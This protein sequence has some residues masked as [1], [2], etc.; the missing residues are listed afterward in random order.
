MSAFIVSS[1]GSAILSSDV[2]SLKIDY[3]NAFNS[4][5]RDLVL[6][7]AHKYFPEY[8][9]YLWQC[10]RHPSNLFFSNSQISSEEGVQQGDPLGPLLFSLAINEDISKLSSELN[11]WYL[12]DGNLADTPEK[13]SADLG[14]LLSLSEKQGLA[15]NSSKC[16]LII[17]DDN[18]ENRKEIYQMFCN[19]IPQVKVVEIDNS[20]ILGSPLGTISLERCIEDKIDNA[21]KL[22]DRLHRIDVH[23]AFFLLKNCLNVPKMTYLLRTAPCFR[24][25]SLP[26]LD[27]VLRQTLTNLLNIHFDD[28]AW[29]QATLPVKFGG[30]G[31][32]KSVSLSI[33]AFLASAFSSMHL[34]EQLLRKSNLQ[35]SKELTEEYIQ[36]WKEMTINEI[37]PSDLTKQK[38]WDIPICDKIIRSLHDAT[39]DNTSKARIIAVSSKEASCWLNAYPIA[40]IGLKLSNVMFRTC[41]AFR[42]GSSLCKEYTCKCG[43]SVDKLGLHTLS[44]KNNKGKYYRH[45]LLNDIIFRALTTAD[46]PSIKEPTGI[47]RNDGKRPD[48]MSLVPYS[49]GRSLLWDVTVV[50][51]LAKSYQREALLDN[52]LVAEKAEN[53][54]VKKYSNI[55]AEQYTFIPIGFESMG[56]FD[57]QAAKLIADLGKRIFLKTGEPRSTQFLKQSISMNIQRGNAMCFMDSL[58]IYDSW[59]EMD[60]L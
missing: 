40:A 39:E 9:R 35:P 18:E 1:E 19:I 48:G 50:N 32:R 24:S 36:I 25:N 16:E 12:D 13:V 47:L 15:I 30:L 10:Y 14:Y 21:T 43:A 4:I 11:I 17:L 5:R 38:L 34:V 46:I 7:A 29:S 26:K 56:S 22:Q 52:G 42:I 45:S 49:Y 57:P 8:T 31:V 58:P 28:M 2:I 20:N 6:S 3:R 60:S 44:C 55:S 53:R 23:D 51:T 27:S 41:I 59:N 33:P 54:K 37:L